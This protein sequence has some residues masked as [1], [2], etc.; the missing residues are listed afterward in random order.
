[1][2]GAN[3]GPGR[4]IPAIA[5]A[6]A[7]VAVHLGLGL[8]PAPPFSPGLNLVLLATNLY[9]L[10]AGAAVLRTRP[11]HHL[12]LFVAG[13]LALVLLALVL[14]DRKPLFVLLAVLYAST[15]GSPFLLGVFA[16]FVL[17]FVIFQPYAFESLVPLVLAWAVLWEQRRTARPFHRAALA[18][19][20]LGLALLLF[21]LLHLALQDSAQTLWRVLQR[22][23]V[24]Q[25]LFT[26]LATA[27]AATA[28]VALWGIPL[29]Y[30]LARL[31]FRG[32]GLVETLVDLPIL[33]PQPVVGVAL[34]ALLGPGSALGQGLEAVLGV[35]F[36][37]T[38]AGIVAA[39][40]FVCSPFLVK[41]AVTAF[42]G[43]PRQLEDASRTLGASPLATFWHVALALAWR[44]VVGGLA[45]AWA[46]AVSEFG[47]ILLFASSPLS[48]P[49][50]V[51]NEFLRSGLTESRPIALLLLLACLW[52]FLALRFGRALLPGAGRGGRARA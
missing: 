29:A 15:F 36:S 48:G 12:L 9:A 4:H 39:Q 27:T 13:Y 6:G 25:A 19:G 17:S 26:S 28:L 32:K 50:L 33:V 22:E 2:R 21:P 5:A 51:H 37:G 44:G 7:V 30:A 41:S 24:R 47:A 43:V 42:E 11:G 20:L 46:R 40:V 10:H 38:Y 8:L 14:L 31:D 49:V 1:V 3:A 18:A 16:V 34:V 35:R 45:L 52:I 23:D